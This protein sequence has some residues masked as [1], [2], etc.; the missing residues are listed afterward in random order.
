LSLIKW[1]LISLHLLLVRTSG[2]PRVRRRSFF[3]PIG[4][5]INILPGYCSLDLT[6]NQ[7]KEKTPSPEHSWKNDVVPTTPSSWSPSV[8]GSPIPQSPLED[9]TASGDELEQEPLSALSSEAEEPPDFALGDD[10]G[11]PNALTTELPSHP[12][13]PTPAQ[14]P[15]LYAPLPP[16]SSPPPV[17]SATSPEK[18]IIADSDTED[19]SEAPN[20]PELD[21]EADQIQDEEDK[22]QILQSHSDALDSQ[23]D[24]LDKDDAQIDEMLFGWYNN[25]GPANDTEPVSSSINQAPPED[26]TKDQADDILRRPTDN[27]SNPLQVSSP[28]SKDRPDF[29]PAVTPSPPGPSARSQAIAQR[30]CLNSTSQPDLMLSE[31]R[32]VNH[33][34]EAW[35]NP[36]FMH[37]NTGKESVFASE[38]TDDRKGLLVGEKT[39]FSDVSAP[40]IMVSNGLLSGVGSGK[41]VVA[42]NDQASYDSPGIHRSAHPVPGI[43]GGSMSGPT[44]AVGIQDSVSGRISSRPPENVTWSRKKSRE[45]SAEEPSYTLG[46]GPKRRRLANARTGGA[47]SSTTLDRAEGEYLK[48]SKVERPLPIHGSEDG[49][50]GGRTLNGFQVNLDNISCGEKGPSSF[51]WADLQQVLLRTGRKRTVEQRD[52]NT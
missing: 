44:S 39:S 4:R 35:T 36:S 37:R 24:R 47:S 51:S 16:T 33:D 2:S 30:V 15:K 50:E 13:P 42:L 17:S 52:G 9:D 19:E 41:M 10:L 14:R 12:S 49:R 43:H 48:V 23:E 5:R 7:P 46:N 6:S 31:I 3:F 40:A 21:H 25:A 1:K 27:T 45:S 8:L 28:Q 38:F 20:Q 34:K 22:P 18:N 29:S 32:P 26:P 11:Q